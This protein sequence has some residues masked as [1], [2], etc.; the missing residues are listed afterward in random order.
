MAMMMSNNNKVCPR[1]GARMELVAEAPAINGSPG[2][3]AWLC[4]QCGAA[5]SALVFPRSSKR[6][7]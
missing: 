2:L 6:S 7:G 4:Q 1:C 5:D 3:V